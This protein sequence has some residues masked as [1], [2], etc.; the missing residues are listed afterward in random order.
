MNPVRSILLAA[1]QN[2]WLR[3]RAAKHR[4]VRQTVSRFMPGEELADALAAAQQLKEK[5]IGT[6]FTHLGENIKDASEAAQVAAHY[7]E[8]LRR[9]HDSQLDTEISVKPTQLGLDLSFEICANHL[10]NVVAHEKPDR[11]VWIDMESSQYVDSTLQLYRQAL[12]QFPNVGLCLQAYLHRTRDDLAAL[13]PL[14]PSIRLVKGAYN[15]PP[16]IAFAKKSEVD[17]NYYS[18]AEQMLLAKETQ[19]NLRM[20]FGTHDIALI[21]RICGFAADNGLRRSAVEIQM[22][23]G[24]QSAAQVRLAAEGYN[25]RV[26]VAYGSHWYAWFVRRLAERPANLWFVIRNLFHSS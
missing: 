3:D 19:P 22:L 7:V 2:A 4:F 10:K 21:W 17:A 16:T 24:I 12:A 6:V 1:S 11:I 20:A 14:H 26:L 9:I 23:F 13:L 15:E 25:S 5:N 8:V 18:L